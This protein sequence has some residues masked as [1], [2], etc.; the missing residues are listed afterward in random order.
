MAFQKA[1]REKT[2]VRMALT[3]PTNAGKTYSAIRVAYGIIKAALEKEKGEGKVTDEEIFDKIAFIDTERRR[4]LFYAERDDLPLETGEFNWM[5]LAPPYTVDKYISAVSEASELVGPNGVIIIDSL[6][7]AWASSGGVLDQKERL[8]K[9]AGKNSYTAW[10]EAGKLQDMLVNNV[11]SVQSHVIATMRSKM[12]YDL[13]ENDKGKLAPKQLGLAPVQRED[14]EYEFDITL[15]LEKSNHTATIIKDTTF[16]SQVADEYENIGMLN[17]HLGSQLFK[18]LN[19]GVNTKTLLEEERVARIK[20]IQDLAKKH[21]ELKTLYKQKL[22]PGTPAKE[23]SVG[24]ARQ[25]LEQ[26]SEYMR[27][28]E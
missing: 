17:E 21:P 9:Q 22:H 7:H 24:Q 19:Q 27:E 3:G 18:W 2:Q 8:Q 1:K 16:L 28:E 14:T 20:E 12:K 10:H 11:L 4:G 13:V 25:V 5:D 23:L 15:M 6:T 26:F